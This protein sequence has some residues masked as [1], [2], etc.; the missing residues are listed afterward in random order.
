MPAY[1]F[2]CSICNSQVEI[3]ANITE[4]LTIPSCCQSPMARIYTATAAVFR[5]TGWG[6]DKR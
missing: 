3:E 1:D 5:G 2:Q 4:S 6:K